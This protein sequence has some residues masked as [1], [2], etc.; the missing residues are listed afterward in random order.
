MFLG[1]NTAQ[2]LGL[3]TI[4]SGGITGALA[5]VAPNGAF[6]LTLS[7]L[8]FLVGTATAILGALVVFLANGNLTPVSD[9]RLAIG[10]VVNAGLDNQGVVTATGANVGV[11]EV[12]Q[13]PALVVDKGEGAE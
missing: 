7:A 13:V 1:R 5:Q 2:W 6:G 8:I 10:Q 4:I 11:K 3:F 12:V 9:P